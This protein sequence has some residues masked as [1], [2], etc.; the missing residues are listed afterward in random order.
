MFG[1]GGANLYGYAANDPLNLI[2]LTGAIPLAVTAVIGAGIG[3]A[4]GYI[5]S[6]NTGGDR[7]TGALKGAA[8]GAA[9]GSGAAF[10]GGLAAAAGSGLGA[11][12]AAGALGGFIGGTNGSLLAKLLLEGDV[13]WTEV[14]L[15]GLLGVGVGVSEV[16]LLGYAASVGYVSTANVVS[17]EVGIGICGG[18]S[19]LLFNTIRDEVQE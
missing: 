2:D 15:S 14:G 8:V 7:T 12:A 10:F 13:D 3:A 1:G 19:D 11:Q 16:G 9:I 5:N 18:T 6:L 4:Y 17:L